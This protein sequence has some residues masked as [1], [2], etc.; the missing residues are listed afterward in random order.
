MD[1]LASMLYLDAYSNVSVYL[2]SFNSHVTSPLYINHFD[3]ILT[4]RTQKQSMQRILHLQKLIQSTTS[5]YY[6]INTATDGSIPPF[7][8][9]KNPLPSP[10]RRIHRGPQHPPSRPLRIRHGHLTLLSKTE[11]FHTKK[12]GCERKDFGVGDDFVH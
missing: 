6:T 2:L 3:F 11:K 7:T 4:T 12:V 1:V 9:P 8:R 5:N 10:L